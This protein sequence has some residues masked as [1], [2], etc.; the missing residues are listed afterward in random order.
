M[1]RFKR[2]NTIE[3]RASRRVSAAA[4]VPRGIAKLSTGQEVKLIN[5]SFAGAVLIHSNVVLSPG[6]SVRLKLK[7]PG[8]LIDLDGRIQR[9]RV[10]ALKQE[11]VKYEAAVVFD[12]GLPQE[13]AERLHFLDAE[14]P[15]AETISLAKLNPGMMRLP[16]KAE[17]WILST[18]E[19]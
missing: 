19:S 5:I 17:L 13:L 16:D 11:K 1:A 8:S 10:I 15:Q 6:S 4:I 2:I 9:C 3:R 18:R 7:I 14:N 12:G